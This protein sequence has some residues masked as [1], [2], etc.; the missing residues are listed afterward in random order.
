MIILGVDPGTARLGYG[1][2]TNESHPS[3][4]RYGCITTGP[5]RSAGERLYRIGKDF[6]KLLKELKPDVVAMETIYF[7][8]NAKTII[9]V[10]QAQGVIL[11][12]ATG[13]RIPVKEYTPLEI[14]MAV[15]GYGRAEKYQIKKIV[16][17]TL[18][19]ASAPRPDDAA[20]ALAIALCH[21]WQDGK[22]T[23]A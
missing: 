14:K 17:Q 2:I 3:C 22:R 15:C 7:F 13:L 19:L 8:K 11:I 23:Y 9:Q 16:Q 18:G 21:L 4:V 12:A 6:R 5:S 20:D 10:S 1:A